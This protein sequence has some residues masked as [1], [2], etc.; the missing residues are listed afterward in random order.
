M[1]K[2][3]K[4]PPEETAAAAEPTPAAI[5]DG[6]TTYDITD[7]A[8]PRIALQRIGKDQTEIRLTEEQARA[9]L[10]AGHIRPKPTAEASASD[11]V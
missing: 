2:P 6:K 9:E 7:K 5:D 10:L 11:T 3:T 1:A 8:P 4:S